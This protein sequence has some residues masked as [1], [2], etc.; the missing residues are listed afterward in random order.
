MKTLSTHPIESIRVHLAYEEIRERLIAS[1]AAMT[2]KTR[3]FLISTIEV[4]VVILMGVLFVIAF[5]K[6]RECGIFIEHY[7]DVIS[8]MVPLP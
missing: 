4:G 6:I 7:S 1:C 5:L 8:Q 3:H 2:K